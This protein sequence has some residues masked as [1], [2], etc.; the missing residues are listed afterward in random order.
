M[1]I[2]RVAKRFCPTILL[3]NYLEAK[4]SFACLSL[5]TETRFIDNL[6][7]TEPLT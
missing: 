1:R 5:S 2:K 3:E 7:P 4:A 6:S